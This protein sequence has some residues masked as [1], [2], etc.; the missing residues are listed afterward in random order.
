MS[1]QPWNNGQPSG[2]PQGGF[3]PPQGG[4]QQ[5]PSGYGA[6]QPNQGAS[7]QGGYPNQPG[8]YPQGG[9]GAQGGYPQG[10]P[11]AQGGYQQGAPGGPGGPVGT[12]KKSKVPVIVAGVVGAAVLAGGGYFAYNFFTGTSPSAATAGIP[13]DAM[14]VVEVSLNPSDSDKLALKNIVEKFPDTGDATKSDDY[15]EILWELVTNEDTSDVDYQEDIKPWLGNSIS[16]GVLESEEKGASPVVS[17]EVTDKGKADEYFKDELKDTELKYFF[18]DKLVVVEDKSSNVEESL[19][20]GSVKDDETYKSDMDA[21]EGSNLA[22]AWISPKAVDWLLKNADLG[23]PNREAVEGLETLKTLH[24]A[25]GLHVEDNQLSLF[26]SFESDMD[27]GKG[28]DV[29]ELA[30]SLPGDAPIAFGVSM[31][32]QMFGQLWEQLAKTEGVKDQLAQMGLE[33][34]DDLKALLGKQIAGAIDGFIDGGDGEAGLKVKTDDIKRHNE[35]IDPLFEQMSQGGQLPVEREADGDTAIYAYG[36]SI[37]DVKSGALK[38][39]DLFKKVITDDAQSLVF[40]NV[41]TLVK[42]YGNTMPDDLKKNIE[43]I[44][45]IGI[46]GTSEGK[47][48][49]AVVKVVFND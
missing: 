42:D 48:G 3:Q 39:N 30:G 17:I 45:A 46:T 34:Q 12:K 6:P 2:G 31:N 5:G 37:D 38:D 26:T 27:N 29:R 7:Q 41:G 43:P 23:G 20:K 14:A 15:K 13:Q 11:G 49:N 16:L 40:V 8:G 10:G 47:R 18:H 44:A 9:P 25:A 33:S 1:Q 4:P 35:I 19:K 28:D 22:S 36:Y 21:L 24:G 32:D